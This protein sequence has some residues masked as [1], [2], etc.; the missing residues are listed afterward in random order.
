[1]H[2]SDKT[3]FIPPAS[4]AILGRGSSFLR[5]AKD[6]S[7]GPGGRGLILRPVLSGE[8]RWRKGKIEPRE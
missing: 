4:W 5:P 6:I 2:T 3:S 1:M 7:P 8:K